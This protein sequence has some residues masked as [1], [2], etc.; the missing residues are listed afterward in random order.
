MP[1]F[2]FEHNAG[3]AR[4]KSPIAMMIRSGSFLMTIIIHRVCWQVSAGTGQSFFEFMAKNVGARRVFFHTFLLCND[5]VPYLYACMC[6]YESHQ[7]DTHGLGL[8]TH[9]CRHAASLSSL[10]T[11][12]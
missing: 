6:M 11:A 8:L 2:V 1:A 4:L 9:I 3:T 10:P 12:M 5:G 7:S